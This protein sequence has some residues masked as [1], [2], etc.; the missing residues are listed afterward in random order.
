MTCLK[1][2]QFVVQPQQEYTCTEGANWEPNDFVPDCVPASKLLEQ[3]HMV[4][5][6][7]I[8]NSDLL[9]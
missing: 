9:I 4:I 3:L 8:N 2:S 1:V 7:Y 5:I 6:H